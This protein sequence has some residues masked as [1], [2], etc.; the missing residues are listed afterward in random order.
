MRR[1]IILLMLL[2]PFTNFAQNEIETTT[3]LLL[4]GA[5]FFVCIVAGVLLAIGFQLLL[6]V[7]SVAAGI[8]AI[9]ELDEHHH[10]HHDTQK[11][12]DHDDDDD[13]DGM[14]LGQKISTG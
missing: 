9:P 2:L 10:K 7:L 14:N 4:E 13:D 12:K 5:N 6:T 1:Y 3:P 11:Y 8:T